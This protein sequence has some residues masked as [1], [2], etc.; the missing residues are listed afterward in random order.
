MKTTA[1]L[2]QELNLAGYFLRDDRSIREGD[3]HFKGRE[4]A[5][6]LY[7]VPFE[8]HG[9]FGGPR[10]WAVHAAHGQVFPCEHKEVVEGP[11]LPLRYGSA[12]T[13]V[14]QACGFYRYNLHKWSDWR[15]GPVRTEPF[16][17]DEV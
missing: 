8:R 4:E 17:D 11:R 9:V 2:E 16:E 6:S 10:A 5:Y 3:P 15:A 14:C 12:A 13:E 7:T 1:E